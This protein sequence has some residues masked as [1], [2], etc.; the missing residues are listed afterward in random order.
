MVAQLASGDSSSWET[1]EEGVVGVGGG[2]GVAPVS[3]SRML[4]WRLMG[5]GSRTATLADPWSL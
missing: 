5:Q 1:A 4:V 3:T 2:E